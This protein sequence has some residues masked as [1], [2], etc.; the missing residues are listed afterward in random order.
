VGTGLAS[1][2]PVDVSSLGR[3]GDFAINNLGGNRTEL[4]HL[5]RP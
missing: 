1:F 2:V 4:L 3:Y 5:N